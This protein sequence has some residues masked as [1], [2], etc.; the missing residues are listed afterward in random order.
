MTIRGSLSSVLT[1]VVGLIVVLLLVGALLGQPV[2]LSYVETGS[3][4]PTI[5]S[6]DGF[7]AIPTAVS[8][9]VETGDV[10]VFEAQ[11]ID[12]G[13]LTTHRVVA[14]T[15]HG[16]V[17]RGD[18]NMVTDQDGAEPHVTDGQVVAKALQVNGEVV[19]IPHL[20]TAVMGI[21]SGLE[22]TQLRLASLLGTGALLGSSGLSALLLGFGIAVLAVSFLLERGARTERSRSRQRRP[23]RD[24]FDAKRVVLALALVI[25]LVS[26]GTMATMSGSTET[27]IVSSEYDSGAHHVIAA[28]ETE[29]QTYEV[30]HNGPVPVVTMF[31]PSSDGVTVDEEP[32]RLERGDAV[33][34]T[35][36][37]TAPPETG[38]YLRSFSE[39]RYFAVL[40]T[41]VIA[42]LHTIHP[43]LAAGAVT[44]VVTGV[45]V[46]PFALLIGTGTIRT[47]ERRRTGHGKRTLW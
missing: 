14:E 36:G 38:Y 31:E 22:A 16:Y 23:R 9:P 12:G 37:V 4:E 39:Y 32:K 5:E 34:V 44:V 20:G 13:G 1:V 29:T 28:G 35:V 15:D 18:A 21:Q 8:G 19:T 7:I 33:N 41:P 11:E 46:L 43:W 10:V 30:A 47:R 17:T 26:A 45:F 6:G 2:L 24:V 42:T 27:G 3:M 25:A 40:P